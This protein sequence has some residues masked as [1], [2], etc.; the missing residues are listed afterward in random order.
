MEKED[1]FSTK[2]LESLIVNR[3]NTVAGGKIN[4]F[5]FQKIIN[6]REN[7]FLLN[8]IEYG[9]ENLLTISLQ[10][11]GTTEIFKHKKLNL[12]FPNGRLISK[13]KFDDL[14]KLILNIP[15]QYRYFNQ[16]LNYENDAPTGDFGLA[17]RIS[18]D[19]SSEDFSLFKFFS[20]VFRY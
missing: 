17:S 12:L 16:S 1:L 6:R 8:V 2:S 4:W 7:P 15:E 5:R 20:L 11:R 9:S 18:S 13:A 19:E 14:Q 10:K 3:K